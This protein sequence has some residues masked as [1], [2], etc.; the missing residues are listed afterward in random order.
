M[1]VFCRNH[2]KKKVANEIALQ[3]AVAVQGY[4]MREQPGRRPVDVLAESFVT[5]YTRI[6]A[7]CDSAAVGNDD[8]QESLI[9]PQ[10][11]NDEIEQTIKFIEHV[12]EPAL[13]NAQLKRRVFEMLHEIFYRLMSNPDQQDH[14]PQF[15]IEAFK[16]VYFSLYNDINQD[17][18][19]TEDLAAVAKFVEE[20]SNLLI[21]K[22]Y[23][24]RYTRDSFIQIYKS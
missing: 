8:Q 22:G 12:V 13:R 11:T 10:L 6:R 4:E 21:K 3:G 16:M 20:T 24:I 19:Q 17:E 14:L 18:H 23:Q 15:L 2:F 7:E 9:Q 1:V 5:L